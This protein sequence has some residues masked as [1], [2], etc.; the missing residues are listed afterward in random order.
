MFLLMGILKRDTF[1]TILGCDLTVM[2]K[3]L[4]CMD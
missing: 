1:K 2:L 3:R 4:V